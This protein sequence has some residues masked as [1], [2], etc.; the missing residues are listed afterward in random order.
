MEP[1]TINFKI[2]LIYFPTLLS[3]NKPGYTNM[4]PRPFLYRQGKPA[5]PNP[6]KGYTLNLF[7][8]KNA[9]VGVF[10]LKLNEM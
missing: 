2:N 1:L 9:L 8:K 7:F 4:L 10:S 5:L 6:G 3:C